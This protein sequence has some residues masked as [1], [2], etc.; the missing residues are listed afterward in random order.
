MKHA[1]RLAHSV[2][3][4]TPQNILQTICVTSSPKNIF[5]LHKLFEHSPERSL[6]HCGVAFF[7]PK[8][9]P[10]ACHAPTSHPCRVLN[11]GATFLC[12]PQRLSVPAM[13]LPSSSHAACDAIHQHLPVM[14]RLHHT[15]RILIFVSRFDYLSQLR[16]VKPNPAK[17][18]QIKESLTNSG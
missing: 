10:V 16:K 15:S 12:H 6:D 13:Q 11:L 2:C 1:A 4:D 8:N 9:V 18:S 7:F 14:P 17:P 3:L 5:S